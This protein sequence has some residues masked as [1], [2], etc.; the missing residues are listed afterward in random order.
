[1]RLY[2][3]R[4]LDGSTIKSFY[5]EILFLENCT[6][7]RRYYILTNGNEVFYIA[8]DCLLGNKCFSFFYLCFG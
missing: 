3:S 1:M 7:N 5:N 4:T 8:L 2:K 6:K